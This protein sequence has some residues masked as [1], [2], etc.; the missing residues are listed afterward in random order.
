MRRLW[1]CRA[2]PSV[3]ASLL[4]LQ[5]LA[6]NFALTN[7]HLWTGS[8]PVLAYDGRGPAMLPSAVVEDVELQSMGAPPAT[9]NVPGMPLAEA[10]ANLPPPAML[11]GLSFDQ[12]QRETLS[13]AQRR[14]LEEGQ[15]LSSSIDSIRSQ[16]LEES[17]IASEERL[18][19]L[20][21]VWER[22]ARLSDIQAQFARQIGNHTGTLQ[23]LLADVLQQVGQSLAPLKNMADSCSQHLS[24]EMTKVV[25]GPAVTSALGNLQA[26]TGLA[27]LVDVADVVGRIAST[28]SA[29][30]R[31]SASM[32]KAVQHLNRAES[33]MASAQSALNRIVS[34][35]MEDR[36]LLNRDVNL[37]NVEQHDLAVQLANV[38]SSLDSAHASVS[39]DVTVLGH[40]SLRWG[41][42]SIL[43]ALAGS[44]AS[45]APG[46]LAPLQGMSVGAAV[47]ASALSLV[48]RML[49]VRR[50]DRLASMQERHDTA[51]AEHA[52]LHAQFSQ[53][54]A[55]AAQ[56][57][58]VKNSQ[59]V[60]VHAGNV[61]QQLKRLAANV[62]DASAFA[63]AGV[64]N[65]GENSNAITAFQELISGLSCI[66]AQ[67]PGPEGEAE[68][69]TVRA[70]LPLLD[71]LA[72]AQAGNATAH[73]AHEA[74]QQA[75]ELVRQRIEHVD[76]APAGF[77][78]G[79]KR[80][81]TPGP[82]TRRSGIRP[83][84]VAPRTPGPLSL[85]PP[86]ADEQG[87]PQRAA[88][89]GAS[90][91]GQARRSSLRPP[92]VA[93]RGASA[94]PPPRRVATP[95][96]RLARSLTPGA[97]LGLLSR[98]TNLRRP[99]VAPSLTPPPGLDTESA[100]KRGPRR[101]SLRP[102]R[103][104]SLGPHRRASSLGPSA[105]GASQEPARLE[106]ELLK[107][108]IMRMQ[109]TADVE[110]K[111]QLQ[112]LAL[113]LQDVTRA[114]RQQLKASQRT[115]HVL[116][117]CV[118]A[119]LAD[120]I[121]QAQHN[122][123]NQ[124][125]EAMRTCL[126]ATLDALEDECQHMD[127]L[128]TA[129]GMGGLR[130]GKSNASM[131]M[132]LADLR[133]GVEQALE[134]LAPASRGAAAAAAGPATLA[135]IVAMSKDADHTALAAHHAQRDGSLAPGHARRARSRRLTPTPGEESLREDGRGARRASLSPRR[136]ADGGRPGD[137]SVAWQ[138]FLQ[139]QADAARSKL[140]R[141]TQSVERSSLTPGPQHW[142]RGAA[143][144][145]SA[146]GVLSHS[147]SLKRS[148]GPDVIREKG[149]SVTPQEKGN[150]RGLASD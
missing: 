76:E 109:V 68:E 119:S 92:S 150:E 42:V 137:K 41:L 127:R 49:G 62:H 144:G 93:P 16:L 87:A 148:S 108:V 126:L 122:M 124:T 121:L 15:H 8:V 31:T 7:P 35:A 6:P 131:S 112:R 134:E 47:S 27:A 78:S 120:K 94:T 140:H 53:V 133:A 70:L 12:V 116:K 2:R 105:R 143:E 146:E 44:V 139:R 61:R 135:E 82:R 145:A 97:D 51:L 40:R 123:T 106:D 67:T 65:D 149:S 13:R 81:G 84:S 39:R 5:W 45:S 88:G 21:D 36:P 147:R 130:V 80:R 110:K 58:Y 14:M 91:E 11:E 111:K 17:T 66:R 138:Q 23:P 9:D 34:D 73:E 107:L 38:R 114:A 3:L 99:S 95:P 29:E 79:G 63:A 56:P 52:A 75:L 50:L 30:S 4:V 20:Q 103:E 59:P 102:P 55:P 1:W 129:A 117:D 72:A 19:M 64:Q 77:S 10:I 71:K 48:G 101:A 26:L 125:Q 57:A 33:D 60:Y 136:S 69:G 22:Y 96:P 46:V 141:R 18:R 128:Q 86:P 74:V 90:R 83:P 142:A 115:E 37:F 43:L 100:G 118:D 89:S 132:A 98:P 54:D 113:R 85:T 32:K 24:K 25:L 28:C 104:G